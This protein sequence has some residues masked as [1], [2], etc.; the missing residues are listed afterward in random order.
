MPVEE[1]EEG[2]LPEDGVLLT[3]VLKQ[4]REDSGIKVVNSPTK[5]E[6]KPAEYDH[7]IGENLRM[8]EG[9]EDTTVVP[10]TSSPVVEDEDTSEEEAMGSQPVI[11]LTMVDKL[12]KTVTNLGS[13]IRK[14]KSLKISAIDLML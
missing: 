14:E 10:L 6:T 13:E 1:N 8:N 11:P 7:K 9:V 2:M 12:T 3:Y 5:P 4:N